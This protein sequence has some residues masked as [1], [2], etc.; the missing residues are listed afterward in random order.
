MCI[1]NMG[2]ESQQ[3][4]VVAL[5]HVVS[6]K[7]GGKLDKSDSQTPV[8]I[9]LTIDS[10]GISRV[11][12]LVDCPRYFRKNSRYTAYI[13][14]TSKDVEGVQVELVNTSLGRRWTTLCQLLFSA[15]KSWD[16]AKASYSSTATEDA[17]PL[18]NAGFMSTQHRQ[19]PSQAS[20]AS[21]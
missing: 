15:T 5:R 18:G 16:A 4:E 14:G 20:S 17:G 9:R 8:I 19:C 11:E 12:R 1:S 10:D 3:S 2:D 13:V 6:W 21:R 7:R